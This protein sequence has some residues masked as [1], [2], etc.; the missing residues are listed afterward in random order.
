MRQKPRAGQTWEYH[1]GSE[2]SVYLVVEIDPYEK[3]FVKLLN[4][5]TGVLYD[6]YPI[7][8]FKDKVLSWRRIA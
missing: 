5:E 6:G 8:R 1:D 7:S 4:L 2:A 3:V